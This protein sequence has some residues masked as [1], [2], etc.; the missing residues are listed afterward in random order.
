VRLEYEEDRACTDASNKAFSGGP[1]DSDTQSDLTMEQP[2]NKQ[3]SV[4]LIKMR[5]ELDHLTDRFNS[6]VG[7]TDSSDCRATNARLVSEN[8]QLKDRIT[9]LEKE[10][11]AERATKRLRSG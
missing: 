8:Q 5:K 1:A 2:A 11:D 7:K 10:R 6:F 4:D 3:I 9:A